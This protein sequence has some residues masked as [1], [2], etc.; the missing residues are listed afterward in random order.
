MLAPVR[1]YGKLK[2]FRKKPVYEGKKCNP[3]CPI[4]WPMSGPEMCD[5]CWM[6]RS[7]DD[8]ADCLPASVLPV[9]AVSK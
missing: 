4:A 5:E 3:K 8:F 1:E 7:P 6:L 2:D 9:R